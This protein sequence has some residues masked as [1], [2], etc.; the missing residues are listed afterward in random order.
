MKLPNRF[1]P[2]V[3][4]GLADVRRKF[5]PAGIT[6]TRKLPE[7][8]IGRKQPARFSGVQKTMRKYDVVRTQ[9]EIESRHSSAANA[10]FPKGKK[11]RF[12]RH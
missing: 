8:V 5:K 3:V 2:V 12:R 11:S 6:V 9:S 1:L 7:S 4:T 10:R